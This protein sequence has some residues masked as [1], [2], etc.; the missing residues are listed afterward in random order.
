MRA[1]QGAVV[2]QM[3]TYTALGPPPAVRAWLDDFVARTGA[4]ELMVAHQTA[5]VESRLRSLALLAEA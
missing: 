2:E 3:L 1:P 5:T 4:D